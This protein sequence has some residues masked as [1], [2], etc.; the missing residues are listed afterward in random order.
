MSNSVF[1]SPTTWGGIDLNPGLPAPSLSTLHLFPW[2]VLGSLSQAWCHLPFLLLVIL[3]H[4]T[5]RS[6]HSSLVQLSYT[7]ELLRKLTTPHTREPFNFLLSL[8]RGGVKPTRWHLPKVFFDQE[9]TD[10]QFPH[11]IRF[12]F[13]QPP[14]ST[15]LCCWGLDA[16][17]C[18]LVALSATPLSTSDSKDTFKTTTSFLN[19]YVEW[20]L[21]T[22]ALIHLENTD[23]PC[24]M[25]PKGAFLWNFLH[26]PLKRFITLC[27]EPLSFRHQ[28][29][30]EK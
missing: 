1:K 26:L 30:S 12:L 23:T 21:Y 13:F 4:N 11:C 8:G 16:T 25:Q 19:S 24:S 7:A 28:T 10:C 27:P 6:H 17:S 18:G 2:N 5:L 15:A 20:Y 3:L 14:G 29:R 22:C 9:A